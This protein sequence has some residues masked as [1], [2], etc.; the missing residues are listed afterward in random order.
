MSGIRRLT[1]LIV[2]D[3]DLTHEDPFLT[4]RSSYFVTKLSLVHCKTTNAARLC[5]F[6]MSFPNLLELEITDWSLPPQG[7]RQGVGLRQNRPGGGLRAFGI[8]LVPNID[9]LL[10]P[11][12]QITGYLPSLDLYW[13]RSYDYGPPYAALQGVDQFLESCSYNLIELSFWLKAIGTGPFLENLLESGESSY[14]EWVLLD[15]VHILIFSLQYR[16]CHSY[17]CTQ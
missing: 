11:L 6:I 8:E 12:V 15:Y 16:Y 13:E 14:I 3:L 4:K 10:N 7:L 1:R 17:A 5:R 9:L 2:N